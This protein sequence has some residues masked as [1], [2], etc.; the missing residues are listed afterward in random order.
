MQRYICLDCKKNFQSK[1]RPE[2][3]VQIIW[4]KY[5]NKRQTLKNLASEY[6]RSI[7]WVRSKITIAKTTTKKIN[8]KGLV[9]VADATFFGRSY[10]FIVFRSPELKRNLYSAC[11]SYETVF[12]YHKGIITIYKQGFSIKAVVLDGKPGVRNLF[13]DVPV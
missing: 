13:R 11:I 8:P 9:I 6:G 12:E 2:R 10:G 5:I 4:D 3:L 1:K 7:N